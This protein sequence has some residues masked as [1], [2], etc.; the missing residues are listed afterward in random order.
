MNADIIDH[1]GLRLWLSPTLRD[2]DSGA[3]TVGLGAN[4]Y[5]LVP[6]K[7]DG[8][9]ARGVCPGECIS[10]VRCIHFNENTY[11]TLFICTYVELNFAKTQLQ[12][13]VVLHCFCLHLR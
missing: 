11:D 1:S 3:L 9:L 2:I 5:W 10:E 13:Q 6:P 12:Q 7:S 8:Y 4:Q